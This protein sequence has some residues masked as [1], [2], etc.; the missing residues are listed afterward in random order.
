L[1]ERLSLLRR[2]ASD[3]NSGDES[4]YQSPESEND[5]QPPASNPFPAGDVWPPYAPTAPPVWP[6]AGIVDPRDWRGFG[7]P[8]YAPPIVSLAARSAAARSRV[9]LSSS[10]GH[11]WSGTRLECLPHVLE[12]QDRY[13]CD[14]FERIVCLG[15]YT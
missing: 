12:G 4:L 9:H 5:P 1:F 15:E 3:D 10:L 8:D 11:S 2:A 7:G 14:E 6:A 13:I